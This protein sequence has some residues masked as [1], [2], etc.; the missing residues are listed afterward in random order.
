MT[1]YQKKHDV[2]LF[3]PLILPLTQVSKSISHLFHPEPIEFPPLC[4]HALDPQKNQVVVILYMVFNTMYRKMKASPLL[5]GPD[6]VYP[7]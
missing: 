6:T 1:L 5:K 2:K 3:R 7:V 4:C